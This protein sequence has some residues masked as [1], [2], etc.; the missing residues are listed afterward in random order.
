ME[1]DEGFTLD[2]TTRTATTSSWRSSAKWSMRARS[3]A[4]SSRRTWTRTIRTTAFIFLKV[5]TD[6]GEE[7]A[8]QRGRRRRCSRRS[9]TPIM[10][11]IFDDGDDEREE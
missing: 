5:V 3:I 6:G 7:D 8:R 4:C 9:T 1:R 2:L 11:E 10:E